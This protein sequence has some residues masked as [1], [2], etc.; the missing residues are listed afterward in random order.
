M[1]ARNVPGINLSILLTFGSMKL[2]RWTSRVATWR[3][4]SGGGWRGSDGAGGSLRLI[5][6]TFLADTQNP[7]SIERFIMKLQTYCSFFCCR[8]LWTHLPLLLKNLIRKE[9]R[10][11]HWPET[12]NLK[13]ATFMTISLLSCSSLKM[14]YFITEVNRS[15]F[16][17]SS[18][19]I[20]GSGCFWISWF[21]LEMVVSELCLLIKTFKNI[22]N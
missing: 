17:S 19:I 13:W 12:A 20:S 21:A 18:I 1:S 16:N 14:N 3:R 5:P 4:C 7:S 10:K 2:S 11:R 8:Q 9:I 15:L 6:G 22:H